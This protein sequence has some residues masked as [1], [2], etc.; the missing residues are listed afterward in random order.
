[1]N[2]LWEKGTEAFR[3]KQFRKLAKDS[4]YVNWSG[5]FDADLE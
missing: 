2:K 3:F 4:V 1:M 5:L